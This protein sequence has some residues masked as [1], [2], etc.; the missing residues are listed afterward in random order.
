MKFK[1]SGILYS[2]VT[3]LVIIIKWK[4]W[5]TMIIKMA[6]NHSPKRQLLL[7]TVNGCW[8]FKSKKKK[9]RKQQARPPDKSYP[10]L[11][12]LY[13]SSFRVC[14]HFN[15]NH[16]LMKMAFMVGRSVDW[17][18]RDPKLTNKTMEMGSTI[19]NQ[20]V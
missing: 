5:K 3:K 18:A 10:E 17:I 1:A 20:N 19:Q 9:K 14:S 15:L 16:K 11:F 7:K 8:F 4:T 13:N 6:F 12:D 2:A